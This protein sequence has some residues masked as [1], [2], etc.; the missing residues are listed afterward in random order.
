[1]AEFKLGRHVHF[2]GNEYEATGLALHSQTYEKLVLYRALDKSETWACP[3]SVWVE[4][5]EFNGREMKRFTHIDDLLP[6]INVTNVTP[7]GVHKHSKPLEK[8]QLFLSLFTGRDDVY[9]KR[10]DSANTGKNGYSPDC[11][12]WWKDVCPKKDRKKVK[13][14]QCAHRNFKPFDENV[15]E[16][17]LSG[18]MTVGS[19]AMLLD[20]TC[21]FLVFDFDAKKISPDNLKRDVTAIREVCAEFGLHMPVERS[22]SG[23]GIHFW[24]FF[25]ENIPAST[26]LKFG[27]SLITCA[28]NRHHY[29]PLKTYDRLIPMQDTLPKGGFGNLIALPLQKQPRAQGNS[30]FVDE[31]FNPY[32]DQ[33]NYL[34]NVHRYSLSEIEQLT[35]K[36]SPASDMGELLHVNDPDDE[37]PWER[38]TVAA[39]PILS[40]SDFPDKVKVVS[41]NMLYIEKRGIKSPALN[42]LKRLAAFSNPEFYKAQAMR[43]ST[44]DKPRVIDCSQET[45]QYM[46]LPRGLQDEVYDFFNEHG[47]ML[48]QLDECNHGRTINV[49]FSRELQGEQQQ[50]SDALLSHNN[51]VLSATTAFGK[52]VVG[53]YLIA[54]RKVSTLILVHR[55]NLMTQWIDRLKDFLRIEEEPEPEFTPMGRQR[56]KSV[57]GQLGGGK[58][59]LSGIIDVAVV[60]S[61]VSGDTVKDVVKNYGMVLV[62]EC[63]RAASFGYE[64]IL[65]AVNAK[66]VY[67]LTATP[68]RKDGHHPIIFMQCGKIRFR[69][70]AKQQ[71]EERPFEH[72]LIPRFTR[73]QKPAHRDDDQWNF[74]DI[75]T[76]I[77]NNDLRN[78]LITQ[79]VV[80]VVNEGRNPIILTERTEHVAV[81]SDILTPQIKNVI[82]LTGGLGQK[83]SREAL[84][85]AA[86]IPKDEQFVI[87]ATGKYVGEGFDMP[88]L[89]TLFLV[90][91]VSWTGTIQQYA[92][93]LHRLFDGKSEVRIYDYV[94]V[95]VSMLERMYQKRLRSYASIGYKVKDTTSAIEQIH[96]IFNRKTFFPVYSTDI[97]VA[98]TEIVIVSP[99]LSQARITSEL[100]NLA[101]TSAKVTVITNSPENHPKKEKLT[102]CINSLKNNGCTVKTKNNIHQ[103]FAVIDQRLVWYGSINFLSYGKSEESVM[104]IESVDI[105]GELLRGIL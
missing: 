93:R 1:M 18:K 96:S 46:C 85:K 35:D 104:R 22:R 84:Q 99:F 92:G 4:T 20:E 12:N 41:A 59:D 17:H 80:S 57:I 56:K 78:C 68:I 88:R 105:A 82:S 70:D 73:F 16:A 11:Y 52:T 61:L 29:L 40:E 25:T 102:S 47:V 69:V 43:M 21:R 44:H 72:Y 6:E 101:T 66:Y 98:K 10:W 65:K 49:S 3:I 91:P 89:D 103:K 81:L 83:Q 50:A 39:K 63:H 15:V 97:A 74:S 28:T 19:Y 14:G 55:K 86:N 75:Y 23:K 58:N 13:C 8:M 53:S 2:E 71:A 64:Q 48:Q 31:N 67:G 79:D 36:L 54:A 90:M 51:G 7:E 27:K 30:V 95:H 26:A 60:Q 87:V 45:E 94:D 33:W 9:A 37:K 76:D 77:Q 62:D 24:V 38:K 42:A 100:P 34:F 5:V 32:P